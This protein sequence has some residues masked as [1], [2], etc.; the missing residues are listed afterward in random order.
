MNN[1]GDTRDSEW[2]MYNNLA[3]PIDGRDLP[4]FKQWV[5]WNGFSLK[6]NGYDFAAYLTNDGKIIFGLPEKTP[7]RA[8]SDGDIS[9]LVQT[10]NFGDYHGGIQVIH[11]GSALGP[12]SWY[13]HMVPRQDILEFKRVKVKKGEVIGSLYK[14]RGHEEGKLVHLHFMLA[15]DAL[16]TYFTNPATMFKSLED[17]VADPQ[18]D[19]DFRVIGLGYQPEIV[20]AN[21]RKVQV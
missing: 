20:I 19:P 17:I 3:Y 8:M 5:K 9:Y 10:S 14:D 12:T 11:A 16:G 13:H 7:V 6:H 18:G 2:L 21:F 15:S 4:G 1:R